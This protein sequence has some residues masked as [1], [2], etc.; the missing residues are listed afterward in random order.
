[1]VYVLPLPVCP[2]ANMVYYWIDM[3]MVLSVTLF[4]IP[5]VSAKSP[6]PQLNILS[7]TPL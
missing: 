1:M 6:F 2:Y 7:L 5:G 3:D 4:L